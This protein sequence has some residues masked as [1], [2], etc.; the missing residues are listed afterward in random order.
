MLISEPVSNMSCVE[1]M[2][3]SDDNSL[4]DSEET[5]IKGKTSSNVLTD[6]VP[7]KIMHKSNTV[8]AQQENSSEPQ[9]MKCEKSAELRLKSIRL[10]KWENDLKLKKVKMQTS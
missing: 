10:S 9:C 8:P 5:L 7:T 4:T 6:N 2:V 1:T 3:M